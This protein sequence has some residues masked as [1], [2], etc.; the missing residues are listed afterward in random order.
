[1]ME[2][3]RREYQ[4]VI[5]AALLHDIGK[6]LQRGS[7]GLLDTKGQHP[8]VSSDFVS[9]FKDYF[10]SFVDIDLLKKQRRPD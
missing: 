1:M 6:M 3:N 5:L 2:F 4:T 7:F 8:Q 10:S 9:A